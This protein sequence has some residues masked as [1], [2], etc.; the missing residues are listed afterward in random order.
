MH[1]VFCSQ[2]EGERNHQME[3]QQALAQTHQAVPSGDL[4][5]KGAIDLQPLSQVTSP[6]SC[7]DSE[8]E[9]H[10]DTGYSSA[11]A[12][13]SPLST[14]GGGVEGDSCPSS[15]VSRQL[16]EVPC[17]APLEKGVCKSVSPGLG[18][19][20]TLSS[21]IC[22]EE[23][24]GQGVAGSVASLAGSYIVGGML[25]GCGSDSS[26]S[27]SDKQSDPFLCGSSGGQ[28]HGDGSISNVVEDMEFL[29]DWLEK[30]AECDS[31]QDSV[32]THSPPAQTPGGSSSFPF[33]TH[34]AAASEPLKTA[35]VSVANSQPQNQPS[36]LA[37]NLES[38]RQPSLLRT[39][40]DKEGKAMHEFPL[41]IRSL[42]ICSPTITLCPGKSSLGAACVSLPRIEGAST[43]K[44]CRGGQQLLM[45][46]GR[47][48]LIPCQVD[49][50][51]DSGDSEE[52][53]L[54][55]TKEEKLG[56]EK[57]QPLESDNPPPSLPDDLLDLAIQCCDSLIDLDTA[58]PE[59][60][61][62]LEDDDVWTSTVE[63]LMAKNSQAPKLT[64]SWD[65]AGN[66]TPKKSA[67]DTPERTMSEHG[68]VKSCDE[69]PSISRQSSTLPPSPV[70]QST[71]I[72]ST[73]N[74]S[75]Q[76]GHTIN[77]KPAPVGGLKGQMIQPLARE[78]TT[79][80]SEGPAPA[81][82]TDMR[83]IR[84]LGPVLSD[85]R[86]SSLHSHSPTSSNQPPCGKRMRTDREDRGAL[87]GGKGL[88]V[89]GKT[90]LRSAVESFPSPKTPSH[91]S[92][93]S[94]GS[95]SISPSKSLTGSSESSP[96][97][98]P[99]SPVLTPIPANGGGKPLNA[100]SELEKHL[101]G[102]VA[103][104]DERNNEL[105]DV[106]PPVEECAQ[107]GSRPFLEQLLTGKISHERYRQ[108][109]YHLLYQERERRLSENGQTS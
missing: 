49:L 90:L 79:T 48:V 18:F 105:E 47:Q 58:L 15:V 92:V 16:L 33:G 97:S 78:K 30:M 32:I 12:S 51:R 82:R 22:G 87:R 94:P 99:T 98:L 101:R 100:M 2:K 34:P 37:T 81:N 66:D 91:K 6:L 38:G 11:S 28:G 9:V 21:A 19:H 61:T 52:D 70:I 27:L 45:C 67:S 13:P 85:H 57:S 24:N 76:P 102:L 64:P 25:E 53:D 55:E 29:E 56:E 50:T 73:L 42:K 63:D 20:S 84:L 14:A 72:T 109:D 75:P 23:L 36:H 77:V 106:L 26:P 107:L 95:R 39:L 83:S 93:S 5:A 69:E 60:M 10:D 65:K 43:G 35:S 8:H 31:S 17:G 40:L 46:D 68:S 103:P 7:T 59:S 71:I 86:Y 41:P 1:V 62:G 74:R 88:G 108:I 80:M 89:V 4:T 54:M 3:L 104:P 96:Y 44:E